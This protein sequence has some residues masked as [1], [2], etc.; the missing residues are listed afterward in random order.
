MLNKYPNLFQ[1]P[2]I[3]YPI[4]DLNLNFDDY[5]KQSRAII[6]NNRQDLENYR[7]LIIEANTPFEFIPLKQAKYG[8][9]LIHGLL[10]TPFIMRDIGER[11]CKKGYLVRSIMLPGH[12]TVPGALLNTDYTDWLQAVRYGIE[13]L[14]NNVEKIFIVGFS[15]G[16]TLGLYHAAK[17]DDISGIM[18]IA[19][20]IRINSPFAFA[21]NLPKKIGL[22][23]KKAQW[24]HVCEEDDYVKYR[25]LTLN[26][27][28]QVYRL[29]NEVKKINADKLARCPIFSCIS[30]ED[31][32]V[33]SGASIDHFSQIKNPLNQMLIYSSKPL[34]LTDPRIQVK[35]SVYPDMNIM[36]F[37]HVTLPVA[38]TNHHYGPQGDYPLASRLEENV[39]HGAFD[40]IDL[41]YRN[42]LYRLK[43]SK[44]LYDR[45]TFN[46]DFDFMMLKMEE[47]ISTL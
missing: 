27:I 10:D 41:F 45:L 13:S 2:K 30:L 15:T 36:H 34:Q 32:I 25:S 28:Y 19:P 6:A 3:E 22:T 46:P 21:A 29:A 24:L 18:M 35:N 31:K 7:K 43:L 37:S 26:A 23:C 40:K 33:C 47:F 38:P 39:K 1:D 42:L 16:A 9:L 4:Y 8:T 44:F 11:L 12:A 5:I 20:A 17:H 14:K